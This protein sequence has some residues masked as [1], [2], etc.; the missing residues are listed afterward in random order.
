MQQNTERNILVIVDDKEINRAILCEQFRRD[1]VI[2]EAEN[3]KEALEILARCRSSVAAVLLD[4]IM[5]VM[6]GFAVLEQLKK[7][8]A[9]AEI[10]VFLI[11]SDCTE[12]KINR[13]YELGVMDIIDKAMSPNFAK[14]RISSVIELF[15]ARER[16][17][18][19]VEV[20]EEALFA[21]AREIEELNTSIIETLAA[22]IEFRDCESGQH[23]HRIHDLTLL[24]LRTLKGAVPTRYAFTE[25][26][27]Q[28]IATAAIMHDVGKIAIP[29]YILNKPGKLTKEEFEIMKS[30][31]VQG[32]ALLDRIP[33]SKKN[34]VYVYAYDICRHHHE[35]WNG[36]GYPD[37]L[38]GDA[39]SIW[40]Q[41]VSLADVYD[42]LTSRRV[43][44]PPYPPDEAI[45]MILNGECGQFHPDL[46]ACL[47]QLGSQMEG[48]ITRHEDAAAFDGEISKKAESIGRIQEN[49]ATFLSRLPG[50]IF[51]YAADREE[52]IDFVSQ[53]LLEL[54][55]YTEDEFRR[56]TNNCFGG[57]VYPEDLERVQREI[58][59]QIAKD[60]ND[61]VTYRIVRK[62][63]TI[64]WVEDRGKI[65]MDPDGKCWFYVVLLDITEKITY[66]QELEKGNDRQG[67]LADLTNDIFFDVDCR[68]GQI[69]I[70]GDFEKRFGRMPQKS[71]FIL[72]EGCE[73]A[74]TLADKPVRF[75]MHPLHEMQAERLEKDLPIPDRDG[76]PV[77]CRY[78]SAIVR[79]SN[80]ASYHHVGRLL[81]IHEWI[82]R[83]QIQAEKAQRDSL[84]GI[85]NRKAAAG[86]IKVLLEKADKQQYVLFLLL[87]IDNFKKINDTYGH[88]EGD[89]VLRHLA[90]KL[91]EWFGT[92]NLIARLG[93]DEFLVF[94]PNVKDR[95][96]TEHMLHMFMEQA[97]LHFAGEHSYMERPTFSIGGIYGDAAGLSFEEL[98]R[99]ADKMLYQ[100]KQ[101]GKNVICLA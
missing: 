100:A 61:Q 84:T 47:E 48:V 5:P 97:F 16:L 73:E 52:K 86:R 74:C 68:S 90:Q 2:E 88:P 56:A 75:L 59:E 28:Q 34:P 55:G 32:C 93:G 94:L 54:Y 58:R 41:V 40:A 36:A 24:L 31:T 42:A 79:K 65:I 67:I 35:R 37:G 7:D 77:W 76:N 26:Q 60:I 49:A 51:R 6:D 17:R 89:L 39:I 78:Q 19:T 57:M 83:E 20:Q 18:E 13:G 45:R 80:D 8:G 91:Q 99:R 92:G 71:D 23:V 70:F 81:D 50:G 46:L 27:M 66:Q 38:K 1:Y 12:E 72:L 82:L 30:H 21:N 10:P 33:N 43:Y 98:Y 22:A 63:G 96:V 95:Q 101:E 3:G 14:R 87:D 25:M 44:K 69:E 9:L 11:T 4:V 64:R 29:D 53:G 62:D 15:R 85:L